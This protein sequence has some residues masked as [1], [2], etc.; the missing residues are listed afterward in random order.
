MQETIQHLSNE[1]LIDY[2]TTLNK[3]T[4]MWEGFK[5]KHQKQTTHVNGTIETKDMIAIKAEL[6]ERGLLKTGDKL[7]IRQKRI[8]KFTQNYISSEGRAPTVAEIQKGVLDDNGRP[9][10]STSVVKWNLDRLEKLGYIS[11]TPKTARSIKI[12][13]PI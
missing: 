6:K 12:T 9:I 7:S 8:M 13:H 4:N 1:A 5:S 11:K 2:H 3:I 10:S